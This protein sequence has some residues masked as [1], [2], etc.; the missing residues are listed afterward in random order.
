MRDYESLGD[1]IFIEAINKVQNIE[2]GYRLIISA[3]T[4]IA[5][6][7]FEENIINQIAVFGEMPIWILNSS[8]ELGSDIVIH[9][10]NHVMTS[11]EIEIIGVQTEGDFIEKI[12]FSYGGGDKTIENCVAPDCGCKGYGEISG[13]SGTTRPSFSIMWKR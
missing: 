9:Y 10:L 4:I 8:K 12:S 1:E 11:T 2:W 3:T 13:L 6:Y 7:E 5:E